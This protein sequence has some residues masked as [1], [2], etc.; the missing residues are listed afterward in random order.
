MKTDFFVSLRYPCLPDAKPDVPTKMNEMLDAFRSVFD[1]EENAD[2]LFSC[3]GGEIESIA[4]E[5]EAAEETDSIIVK[6]LVECEA[7]A[8][9]QLDKSV[10]NQLF[11]KQG[12]GIGAL[13]DYKLEKRLVK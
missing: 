9:M 10:L 13:G 12:M 4:V 6:C 8:K 2:K 5:C 11:Y 1:D 3:K 7:S